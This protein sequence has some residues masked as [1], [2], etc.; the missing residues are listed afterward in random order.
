MADW[1]DADGERFGWC[2]VFFLW[3]VVLLLIFRFHRAS[4]EFLFTLLTSTLSLSF[5]C[6]DMVYFSFFSRR[7]FLEK[8]P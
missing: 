2:L 7:T 1:P 6:R 8:E 4:H 5:F 3:V